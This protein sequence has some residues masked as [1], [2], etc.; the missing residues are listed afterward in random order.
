MNRESAASLVP[1]TIQ[2]FNKQAGQPTSE[3][4]RTREVVD[5]EPAALQE[6]KVSAA[7]GVLA[8]CLGSGENNKA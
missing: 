4:R 6:G 3:G 1:G 7:V 5:G 8:V 2:G